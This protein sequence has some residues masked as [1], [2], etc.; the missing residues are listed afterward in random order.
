MKN[1][2]LITLILS[3]LGA[4]AALLAHAH[5]GYISWKD[6]L[7][8]YVVFFVLLCVHVVVGINGGWNELFPN[9]TCC[10][11]CEGSKPMQTED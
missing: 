5:E 10:A 7:R 4:C 6:Q 1:L 9:L 3:L 8:V 2:A 11:S